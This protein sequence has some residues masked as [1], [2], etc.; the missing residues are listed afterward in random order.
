MRLASRKHD[1]WE[2]RSGEKAHSEHL[3]TFWIPTLEERQNLQI[4]QA[5][6]L[7]FDIEL[8]DE[9]GNIEIQGERMWVIFA[10]KYH[11][12]YLGILDNSPGSFEISPDAYLCFGAEIPFL[13][14]HIIDTDEVPQHYVK[15]QLNQPPE[16]QWPRD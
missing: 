13:P 5:A 16:R 1:Y 14:E 12:F 4:G 10:E 15:W 2:L 8:E 9:E 6:R 3:D 11:S 7:I